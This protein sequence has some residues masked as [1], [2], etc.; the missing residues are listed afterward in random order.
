MNPTLLSSAQIA[1]IEAPHQVPP[2]WPGIVPAIDTPRKQARR[3]RDADPVNGPYA[4][5]TSSIASVSGTGRYFTN[6]F[7]TTCQN[8]GSVQ[9]QSFSNR[10]A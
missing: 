10:A 9:S 3:F 1:F 2:S 6:S 8:C 7:G 5:R 4:R